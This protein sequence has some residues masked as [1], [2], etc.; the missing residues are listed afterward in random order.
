L[1]VAVAQPRVFRLAAAAL[2]DLLTTLLKRY[3]LEIKRL[4]L[5]AVVRQERTAMPQWVATVSI[6]YL[7][8]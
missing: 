3:L 4:L 7:G 1:L 8:L 5:V 2:E 6:L